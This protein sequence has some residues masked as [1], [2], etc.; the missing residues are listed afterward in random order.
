MNAFLRFHRLAVIGVT[1]RMAGKTVV[2]SLYLDPLPFDC[3]QI[4][5]NMQARPFL[6]DE[7]AQ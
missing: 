3:T 2:G 6:L 5:M 7:L 1:S 4:A